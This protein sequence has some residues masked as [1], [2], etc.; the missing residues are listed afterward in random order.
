MAFI[1]GPSRRETF[2]EHPLATWQKKNDK[3]EQGREK[4]FFF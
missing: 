1:H 4:N 2:P 3:K